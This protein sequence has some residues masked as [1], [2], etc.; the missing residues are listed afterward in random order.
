MTSEHPSEAMLQQFALNARECSKE[1]ATHIEQC[2]SCQAD[3]AIYQLMFSEIK[4]QPQ[5]AFDFDVTGVVMP[6]V[7]A[8]K[9]SPV[10]DS[11]STNFITVAICCIAVVPLYLFRRN[12]LFIFSGISSLFIYVS[13][14]CTIAILAYSIFKMYK[15]YQQKM[16]AINFY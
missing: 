10:K 11:F 1:T 13:V 6:Q 14:A 15:R 8:L 9:K 7:Q 12:I 2:K 4:Q 5:P 16:Q 3:V